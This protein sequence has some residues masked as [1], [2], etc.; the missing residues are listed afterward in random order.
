M[1]M[2]LY[3]LSVVLLSA[4]VTA[5]KQDDAVALQHVLEATAQPLFGVEDD[6]GL[7]PAMKALLD[8]YAP[9]V[10][11][12]SNERFF[13][14]SIDYMLPYYRLLNDQGRDTLTDEEYP[15][16][17]TA[18]GSITST[19]PDSGRGLFLAVNSG[20]NDDAINA[21]PDNGFLDDRPDAHYLM[22]PGE[23]QRALHRRMADVS[24]RNASEER[25]T[26]DAPVYGFHVNK[27]Q[28]VI[29]LWYWTF[30]PYN[31]GKSVGPFGWLGNREDLQ[32]E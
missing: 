18:L 26:V 1:I 7:T 27:G 21:Q 6:E 30:Y 29:D 10:N 23:G 3:L 2:R 12:A 20:Q 9:V 22:G 13:P 14:S 16:N 28:G 15:L 17:R 24:S 4:R 19:I 25:P 32:F 5:A 11:L 8:R 31:L